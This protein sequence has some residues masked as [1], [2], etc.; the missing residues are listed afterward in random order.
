MES[1][2]RRRSSDAIIKVAEKVYLENYSHRNADAVIAD[3]LFWD[4]QYDGEN[5]LSY[6]DYNPPTSGETAKAYHL[7]MKRKAENRGKPSR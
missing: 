2:R 6:F 7:F 1:E 3:L 4:F 5:Y